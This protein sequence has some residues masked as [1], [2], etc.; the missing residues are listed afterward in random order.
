MLVFSFLFF[1]PPIPSPSLPFPSLRFLSPLR[2]HTPPYAYGTVHADQVVDLS[3]IAI[4]VTSLSES[5]AKEDV[6]VLNKVS[7][8]F[9]RFLGDPA[10]LT[11]ILT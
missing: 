8:N 5:Q 3:A 7:D 1:F 11:Q 9:P 2:R 10:R 6:L 4:E